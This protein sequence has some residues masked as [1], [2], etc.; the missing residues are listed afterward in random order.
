M[1]IQLVTP[2]LPGYSLFL[3]AAHEFGHA[4]GLEHSQDP[5]ALMAPVYTYTKNFRLP[6]DDIKG[7]QDLYGKIAGRMEGTFLVFVRLLIAEEIRS[8]CRDYIYLYLYIFIFSLVCIYMYIVS[9]SVV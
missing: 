5:G 6:N 7:I 2:P 4:L 1:H 8:T 9:N 3:V